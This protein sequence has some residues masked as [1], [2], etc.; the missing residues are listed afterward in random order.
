MSHDLPARASLARLPLAVSLVLA[1]LLSTAAVSSGA[2]SA[3][4]VSQVYGGGG[5][6]GASFANDF[7]EL[8]NRGSTAVDLSGW[9]VQYAT[10]S[11]TT[12]QPT[13]LSGS[14]APGHYY[15]VQLASAAAVGAPLPA[16][17]ATGTTN[18]AASGGKVALVRDTTAL[19]CGAAAGSC[20]ANALVADLVGY[21]SATDYEGSAPAPALDSATAALRDGAG[22]TDTDANSADFT[23]VAP[24]P[25]NTAS[26][27]AGCAAVPPAGTTQDAV[28]DIDVQPMLSIAIE[29]PSLHF[30]QAAAGTTPA[31][32]SEHVTVTSTRATGYALTVHRSAFS[33][34]DLPLGI[35]AAG[36]PAGGQLGA[37]LVGGSVAPVPV[38][39]NADLLVGTT[40]SAA[41]ASGD[42]WPTSIGFAAP[43]PPVAAGHYTATVTFTV[44]GR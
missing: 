39:P 42:V 10:A 20:S 15:L 21:G 29:R 40:S 31:P 32:I 2:S 26:P 13:P 12:W 5:N 17:D 11:G 38:A 9:T 16:P 24:T 30:G 43:L 41:A 37:G 3:V 22:C 14:L 18:L 7:V 44:I 34:A 6:S 25:R 8:L 27:T 19:A 35:S 1:A 36:A 33:L 23:A 28:V 4:V